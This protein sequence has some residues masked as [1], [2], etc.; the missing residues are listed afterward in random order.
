MQTPPRKYG[1]INPSK[2]T[3]SAEG[4]VDFTPSIISRADRVTV[5]GREFAVHGDAECSSLGFT[6]FFAEAQMAG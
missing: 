4:K 2:N 5:V 3:I 1:S 6:W